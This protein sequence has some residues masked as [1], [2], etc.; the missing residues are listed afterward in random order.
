MTPDDV[1]GLCEHVRTT[2]G[3]DP[4]QWTRWPGGWP[5]DIESA[6][7]DAVFSARAIYRTEHG[8]G[9]YR[10]VEDWQKK[11]E[12]T[13]FSLD[14]LIADIDAGGVAVWARSFGN[15][16]V[17]PGRREDAPCGPSKAA[18]VKESAGKLRGVGINVA[19]DINSDTAATAKTALRSV[20]GIGFAT[21]NYL[22]MLLGVPGVKPDRMIH[23]FLKN[24]TGESFS[25]ARAEQLLRDAAA[26][27]VVQEHVLDHA[28]WWYQ[29]KQTRI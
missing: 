14:A 5:D 21:S 16:Q 4:Q 27:F 17:S 15:S 22:L 2:I 18:T 1:T 19:A 9:I 25:D 13:A 8:R 28:I 29:R 6:L 26:Q 10:N 20:S 3:G 12:R 23:R 7:I 11:R 24:A